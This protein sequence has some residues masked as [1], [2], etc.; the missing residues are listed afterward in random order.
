MTKHEI[1]LQ[2]TLALIEKGYTTFNVHKPEGV[3]KTVSELY[4]TISRNIEI[5]DTNG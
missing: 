4:N 3:G 2:L 1:V 5:P